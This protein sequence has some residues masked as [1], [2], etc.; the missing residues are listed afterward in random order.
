MEAIL[1]STVLVALIGLIGTIARLWYNNKKLKDKNK[2]IEIEND[3]LNTKLED[4]SLGLELDIRSAQELEDIVSEI[5]EHTKVDRFLILSATN[6]TN[7][8]KYA[9]VLVERHQHTKHIKYS[10]GASK[11]YIGFE[12]DSA[13]RDLLTKTELDGTA[14]CSVDKLEDGDYKNIM[15]SEKIKHSNWY[16]LKRSKL[17]ETRDM[18]FYTSMATHSDEPFTQGE[19][20]LLKISQSRLQLWLK[21]MNER[22]ENLAS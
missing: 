2:R 7:P 16:F 19:E 20:L 4:V 1:N 10:L 14:R 15:E 12:F 9:T 11:K 22:N 13:Y 21:D 18:M 6:G 5:F 8:M 17:T 3:D